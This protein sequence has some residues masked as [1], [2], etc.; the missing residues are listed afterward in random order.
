MSS[1]ESSATAKG[2]KLFYVSK[3]IYYEAVSIFY[4]E[5]TFEF[6]S[7]TEMEKFIRNMGLRNQHNLRSAI[8]YY[9]AAYM[10]F[11]AT[12]IAAYRVC[13]STRPQICALRCV[14]GIYE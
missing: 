13:R 7:L 10:E 12:I 1:I 3:Q 11:R 6:T 5:N 14:H 9:E 8:V 2:Q 4:R